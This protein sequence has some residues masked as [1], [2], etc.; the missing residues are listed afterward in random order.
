MPAGRVPVFEA[1]DVVV[2]ESAKKFILVFK[3]AGGRT[4]AV[5]VRY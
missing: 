1:K 4:A 3:C 5:A 2:P